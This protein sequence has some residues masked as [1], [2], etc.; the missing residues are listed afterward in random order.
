MANHGIDI[1]LGDSAADFNEV[2]MRTNFTLMAY[3]VVSSVDQNSSNNPSLLDESFSYNIDTGIVYMIAR[4]MGETETENQSIL[5][6][7]PYAIYI[8][9]FRISKVEKALQFN[10]TFICASMKRIDNSLC[11]LISSNCE[12]ILAH[13]NGAKDSYLIYC[14]PPNLHYSLSLPYKILILDANT[15]FLFSLESSH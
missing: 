9:Y 12:A 11:L 7:T 3:K 4:G 10:D 8:S 15:L 6:F 13:I 5:L 2:S 1:S 14:L